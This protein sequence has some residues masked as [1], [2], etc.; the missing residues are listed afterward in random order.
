M[1]AIYFFGYLGIMAHILLKIFPNAKNLKAKPSKHTIRVTIYSLVLS[2]IGYTVFF[3]G[4]REGVLAG[5][6]FEMEMGHFS[7]ALLG[8]CGDSLFQNLTA[9]VVKEKP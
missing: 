1:L 5:F 4:M 6:G 7:A 9:K 8:F 3:V 2:L